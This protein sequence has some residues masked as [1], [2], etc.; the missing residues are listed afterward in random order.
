[1]WVRRRR[2]GTLVHEPD[3]R[4]PATPQRVVKLL[5][6]ETE[7]KRHEEEC[8]LQ[9]LRGRELLEQEVQ[10]TGQALDRTKDELRALAAS[11]A[12]AIMR[13]RHHVAALSSGKAHTFFQPLL[14]GPTWL[15]YLRHDI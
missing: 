1:M 13:R 8:E 4:R 12:F 5:R 15:V 14:C 3:A 2:L 6:D 9:R 10:S 11:R 7:R